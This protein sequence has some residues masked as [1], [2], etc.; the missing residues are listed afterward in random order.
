MRLTK[1]LVAVGLMMIISAVTAIILMSGCASTQLVN[2]WKDPAY[3]AAPLKKILVIAMRKDQLR[4]RMW[5]D[6]FV[7]ALKE[8]KVGTIAIPSYQL[9]P[10]DIPD[11]LAIA[12]KTQEESFDGVLVIA[13][14]ERGQ[15]TTD[16]P[17]YVAQEPVTVYRRRWGTYAT[18]WETVYHPGY[19]EVQKVFSVRTDLLLPAEE[20]R[21]VWSA[22]SKDIN[23][24]SPQQ[25]RSAVADLVMDKLAKEGLVR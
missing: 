9:F 20:G 10:D 5:E 16:V 1:T 12:E 7:L 23:P 4:R 18:R 3:Q 2:V 22:T 25:F 15:I 13:R 17:G 11:T 8:D 21:L 19:T 6:N 14:V 24:G